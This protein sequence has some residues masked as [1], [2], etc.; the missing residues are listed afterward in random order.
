VPNGRP[1]ELE[2][3]KAIRAVSAF[4][5]FV[6]QIGDVAV[7]VAVFGVFL[8]PIIFSSVFPQGSVSF[9]QYLLR[10]A[11]VVGIAI[12]CIPAAA[13]VKWALQALSRRQTG[14]GE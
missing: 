11:I 9:A 1:K 4:W 3:L 10:T 5:A 13:I 12:A 7:Y 8:A 2:E 14:A 6:W